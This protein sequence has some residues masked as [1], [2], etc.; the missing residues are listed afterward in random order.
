MSPIKFQLSCNALSIPANKY[1]PILLINTNAY[2]LRTERMPNNILLLRD[3]CG[4]K[5]PILSCSQ[6][7]KNSMKLSMVKANVR[8]EIF[9]RFQKKKS[10]AIE[11]FIIN[12]T[13][14]ENLS[15]VNRICF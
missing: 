4:K 3:K 11:I 1:T 8:V 7:N 9:I 5:S 13:D 6:F 14:K 15:L 2:L 10:F 12:K